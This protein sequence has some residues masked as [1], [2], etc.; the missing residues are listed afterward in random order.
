MTVTNEENLYTIENKVNQLNQ[1]IMQMDD[2]NKGI[3]IA[4]SRIP[5][6]PSNQQMTDATTR[7]ND[8]LTTIKADVLALETL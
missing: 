6:T 1:W 3:T 5:V 2:Q 4:A 7:C 8:L